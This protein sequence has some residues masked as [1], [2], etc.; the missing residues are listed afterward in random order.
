MGPSG[1]GKDSLIDQ[2]KK[3]CTIEQKIIFAHRYITRKAQPDQE[4]HVALSLAEFEQRKSADLFA[5]HWHSHQTHYAIGS[6]VNDW[7][8]KGFN[9]VING[10]RS[11]LEQAMFKFKNL[12]PIVIDVDQ[13]V[14][15]KRLIDRGREN[16]EQIE[17]RM[18][19]TGLVNK[20]WQPFNFPVINNNNSIEISAK[21]LHKVMLEII[22]QRIEQTVIWQ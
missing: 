7:L 2:L 10:S 3:R 8:D 16:P 22:N 9:V 19:K 6:E 13:E 4:N 17:K 21:E 1:A 11:Y 14:L 12:S 20:K 18:A 5:M 15:R